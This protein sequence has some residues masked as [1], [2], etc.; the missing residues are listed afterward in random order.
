MKATK[1]IALTAAVLMV[2]GMLAGCASTSDTSAQ[3]GTTKLTFMDWESESMNDKIRATMQ[4]FAIDNT[5]MQVDLMPAP[6]QDYGTKIQQMIAANAAPDV[7]M[8]GNDMAISYAAGGYTLDITPYT[9]KDEAFIKDFYPGS[10]DT[11]KYQ[12]KQAGL[13]GLLN[14]YGIFYNKKLFTDKG[15]ALPT[16]DWTYADMLA[17]ADKLKDTANNQYG[18][19]NMALDPFA[20]S[21]YAVSAGGKAFPDAVYPITKVTIDDKFKEGVNLFRDAIKN[22]SIP[23]TTYTA[24]NLTAMFMEGKVPMMMYGQWAADEL[25]RNAPEDLEW[26]FVPNPKVNDPSTTLDAVGWAISKSTKNPDAAYKLLKYIV[27]STYSEVLP[28]NPVAPA[29]YMPASKGYYQKLKDTGHGDLAD[30]LDQ[31]LTAKNK[32]IVRFLDPWA[33]DANKFG[34]SYNEVLDG[35]AD[36]SALDTYVNNINDVIANATT[37]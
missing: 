32:V 31:M 37:K 13:P 9:S 8:V 36:I 25:I 35:K 1:V 5:G 19:Y 6:L 33:G 18:L 3:K 30:G 17:A 16:K 24:T 26:G 7:F 23:P 4:Q 10:I 21:N 34:T 14:C 27:S 2:L 12:G 29:A 22:G 28:N 15:V 20:M 11:F